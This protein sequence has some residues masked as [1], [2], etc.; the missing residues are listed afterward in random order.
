MKKELI[1]GIILGLFIIVIGFFLL[2]N[3]NLFK[4]PEDSSEDVS[5]IQERVEEEIV[6]EIIE[7]EEVIIE[8]LEPVVFTHHIIDLSHYQSLTPPGSISLG[9]FAEHGYL[10]FKEGIGK[11]PYMHRLMQT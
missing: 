7:D 2:N 5:N 9:T 8:P 10:T 1:I 4:T 11:S 6:N 3:S